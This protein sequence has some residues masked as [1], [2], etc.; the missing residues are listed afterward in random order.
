MASVSSRGP[1]PHSPYDQQSAADTEESWQYL[2]Y[3]SYPA[4][5]GFLPSPASGSLNGFAVVGHHAGSDPAGLS[6]LNLDL[7]Q[8]A[9]S[10][11]S[12][13]DQ[14]EAFAAP[15]PSVDSQFVP[16]GQE[17]NFLTPQGFLFAEEQLNLN[18]ESS[19]HPWPTFKYT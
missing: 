7:D 15:A 17:S 12:F 2:D 14:A 10:A 6:P 9:F 3:A 19:F 8:P 13:P 11:S 16:S 5:V 1:T 4:S 18:G